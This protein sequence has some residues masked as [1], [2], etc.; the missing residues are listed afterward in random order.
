V[1]VFDSIGRREGV[2]GYDVIPSLLHM[3]GV[4]LTEG[5]PGSE[6]KLLELDDLDRPFDPS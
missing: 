4:P 5:Q 6:D 1:E 2:R 3:W